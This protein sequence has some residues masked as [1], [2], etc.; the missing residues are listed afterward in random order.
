MS[1]KEKCAGIMSE[2]ETIQKQL[3][4]VVNIE[5]HKERLK[6][7]ITEHDIKHY[8][9]Q[10]AGLKDCLNKYGPVIKCNLCKDTGWVKS[11]KEFYHGFINFG[12]Q[13]TPCSACSKGQQ[14][15][16]VRAEEAEKAL[17]ARR[18]EEAKRKEARIKK[19]KE[20]EWRNKA[21]QAFNEVLEPI[22]DLLHT[23]EALKLE[24]EYEYLFN[25]I[26]KVWDWYTSEQYYLNGEQAF[27]SVPNLLDK[28]NRIAWVK[29][30]VPFGL[31]VHED[32][33]AIKDNLL[34]KIKHTQKSVINCINDD[35]AP[36]GAKNEALESLYKR[37]QELVAEVLKEKGK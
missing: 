33:Y 9:N 31:K 28:E 11:E 35:S 16:K 1:L 24:E 21:F 26:Y 30:N 6:Y 15:E 32:F 20:I 13:T 18:K 3:G 34:L 4:W 7:P 14:I 10:L 25:R 12:Y 8:A 27:L 17:T 36:Y 5:S 23:Q 19:A 37:L 22:F 2:I 29:E